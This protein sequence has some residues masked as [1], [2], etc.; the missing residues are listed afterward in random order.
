MYEKI[1]DV[2]DVKR[3][4]SPKLTNRYGEASSLLA[5]SRY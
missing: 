5:R 2:D 3:S 4:F 1:D